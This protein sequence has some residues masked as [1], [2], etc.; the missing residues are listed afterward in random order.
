METDRTA[1]GCLRRT[2]TSRHNQRKLDR[3]RIRCGDGEE[4]TEKA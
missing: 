2:L 1:M 4:S 3:K